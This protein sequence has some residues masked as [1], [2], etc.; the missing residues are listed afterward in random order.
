MN[1]EDELKQLKRE[2]VELLAVLWSGYE[3]LLMAKFPIDGLLRIHESMRGAIE[4]I[5]GMLLPKYPEPTTDEPDLETL[6]EWMIDD[7]GCEATDG[8]WVEPD[9]TCPHGHPSWFLRLGLI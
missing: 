6:E 3:I 9:G 5:N 8:C 4:K 7:G 2:L 1:S